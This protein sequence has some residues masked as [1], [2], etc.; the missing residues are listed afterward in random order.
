MDAACLLFLMTR[1]RFF[2]TAMPFRRGINSSIFRAQSAISSSR[3][4]GIIDQIAA[5]RGFGCL[6]EMLA[7]MF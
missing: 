1:L 5:G 4:S 2:T 7:E 3:F 6:M